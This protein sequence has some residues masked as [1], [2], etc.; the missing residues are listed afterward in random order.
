MR[1][2]RKDY[3]GQQ[4][5]S[6]TVIGYSHAKGA[7]SIWNIRCE[8]GETRQYDMQ[9]LREGRSKSCGCKSDCAL[10]HGKS[11]QP[12]YQLW[13]GM[14]TRCTNPNHTAFARYGGRGIT[15]SGRWMVF[16]NFYADMG[17]RPEGK[18]LDRID[19]DGNYE[20]ANCRWA[21]AEEQARGRRNKQ[22]GERY[23]YP[24]VRG[25]LLRIRPNGKTLFEEK[26]GTL[27]EAIDS[28]N[29]FY[30]SRAG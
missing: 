25:Y 10:R 18:S 20:P 8:C 22:T 24:Q 4:F 23:V 17:D 14:I 13:A 26:F 27:Q 6:W 29:S 7:R 9:T 3:T 2:I 12:I 1:R 30:S 5:G 15:V 21:T 11:S 16:D 28:R 19:N